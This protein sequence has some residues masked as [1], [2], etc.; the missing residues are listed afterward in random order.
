MMRISPE[1][2]RACWTSFASAIEALGGEIHDLRIDGPASPEAVDAVERRIGLT[3]P[4]TFRTVFVEFAGCAR[5]RWD[6]GGDVVLPDEFREV[7]C[8]DIHWSL[9]QLV[10]AEESR[11]IWVRECFPDP[12]DPYDRHWH[13]KLAFCCVPNGDHLA[14]DL[15]DAQPGAIVYLSHDDG[16]GHG[17]TMA[18]SFE[19]LIL[20]WSAI[21]G[22]GAE[23]WQWLPFHDPQTSGIAPYGPAASRFRD[24]IGFDPPEHSERGSRIGSA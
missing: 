13:D 23:D 2:I 15:S 22:V 16:E 8:G 11:R 1:A 21:G 4:D 7:F 20:N 5:F 18:D 9:E 14:V 10:E 6:M 24:L 3:L 12:D 17:L 19:S